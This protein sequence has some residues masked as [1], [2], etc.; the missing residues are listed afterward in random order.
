MNGQGLCVGA[1]QPRNRAHMTKNKLATIATFGSSCSR[2][3]VMLAA[4]AVTGLLTARLK[5]AH[6][7][8]KNMSDG[9]S[10]TCVVNPCHG[11]MTREQLVARLKRAG[12]L[13]VSGEDQA[14]TDSYFDTVEY[15]FHGPDGFEADYVASA[16]ISR[17]FARHSMIGQFGAASSSPREITLPA[18]PGSKANLCG[19]SH[20]HQQALCVRTDNALFGTC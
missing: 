14:E 3:R 11:A 4:A 2:R 12:E 13:V 7:E 8:E 20:T 15:R 9:A 5:A 18:R 17:Q 10:M 6:S 16:T 19:S 1:R